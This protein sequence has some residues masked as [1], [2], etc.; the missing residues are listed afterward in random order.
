MCEMGYD[1]LG[2]EGLLMLIMQIL[3]CTCNELKGQI[4]LCKIPRAPQGVLVPLYSF[5]ARDHIGLSEC[6]TL[7]KM[8]FSFY[9]VEFCVSS[10]ISDS[11]F[12]KN[13]IFFLI[14]FAYLYL[15]DI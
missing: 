9:I 14:A 3:L 5:G 11:H 6:F 2:G 10:V 12:F 8:F 4:L 13:L 15:Y 1:L 7:T